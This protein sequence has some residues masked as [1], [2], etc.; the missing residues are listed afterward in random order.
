MDR[1]HGRS[2]LFAP[3]DATAEGRTSVS[4]AAKQV[5]TRATRDKSARGPGNRGQ[6]V[7]GWISYLIDGTDLVSY[8]VLSTI[9]R[10]IGLRYCRHCAWGTRWRRKVVLDIDIIRPDQ[11]LS[12]RSYFFA[13]RS[14]P[15]AV[16]N[17]QIASYGVKMVTLSATGP[18]Q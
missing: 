18:S 17:P 8:R 12:S 1:R 15:A 16:S 3:V 4:A 6:W 14:F 5:G 10:G 7:D 2:T 11:W 13:E 9:K